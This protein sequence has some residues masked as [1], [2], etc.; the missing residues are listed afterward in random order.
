[1]KRQFSRRDF[2]RTSALATVGVMGLAGCAAPG[3]APSAG[4][5]D[6]EAAPSEE[7]VTLQF[8]VDIINEGHVGVRD[9]WSEEFMEMHPNV[10]V[11][12][13]P[14]PWS[15]YHTKIQTMLAAGTPA[16]IYRYVQEVTPINAV[17]EKKIHIALDDFIERDNYDLTAF[18]PESILLYQW[19]G[20]TYGLPRDYGNQNFY[21]NKTMYEEAGIT[22][23]P[24]DWEDTD[25]T[26]DVFLEDMKALTKKSGDKTE[27]WGCTV[28]RG[29]R[30]MA[31]Y[32][33]LSLIHI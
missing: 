8:V 23:P 16:D 29:V 1:M 7:N 11:E 17:H 32:L 4:S 20:N 10:T 9:K 22:P 21:Y 30:P 5:G 15:D 19:E 6:G 18:K 24:A 14:T 33:Y 31:S 12:H 3:A 25:Y 13:Q 28:T 27:Q 2:L 26:F